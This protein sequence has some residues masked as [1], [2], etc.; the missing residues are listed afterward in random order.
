MH[1]SFLLPVFYQRLVFNY[2]SLLIPFLMS[3]PQNLEKIINLFGKK[4]VENFTKKSKIFNFLV[5]QITN[6]D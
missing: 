3:S 2:Y 4:S 5:I 1:F 6:L